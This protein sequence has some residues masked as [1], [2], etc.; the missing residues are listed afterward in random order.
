METPTISGSFTRFHMDFTRSNGNSFYE[1]FIFCKE[2]FNPQNSQMPFQIL[3]T[4][5]QNE[6]ILKEALPDTYNYSFVFSA[7]NAS[8]DLISLQFD[9]ICCCNPFFDEFNMVLQTCSEE[10]YHYKK[11]LF[12]HLDALKLKEYVSTDD[13]YFP[14]IFKSVNPVYSNI[15]GGKGIFAGVSM[16]VSIA[17]CNLVGNTCE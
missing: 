4:L 1:T 6:I 14:D 17:P 8:N 13:L 7:N 11:S 2:T 3:Q 9:N 12:S 16:H 10:Y 5:N 15:Q